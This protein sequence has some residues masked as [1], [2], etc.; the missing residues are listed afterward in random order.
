MAEAIMLRSRRN[1]R[2][3]DYVLFKDRTLNRNE[4]ARICENLA[5]ITALAIK[6]SGLPR[7]GSSYFQHMVSMFGSKLV[8]VIFDPAQGNEIQ[9]PYLGSIAAFDCHVH[10]ALPL[11]D[12][13]VSQQDPSRSYENLEATA[14]DTCEGKPFVFILERG[15]VI[16][17]Y[18]KQEMAK[19]NAEFYDYL[20][21]NGYTILSV[22]REST[23][24]KTY[25]RMEQEG[26]FRFTIDVR[27]PRG[28]L[29]SPEPFHLICG[30]FLS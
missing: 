16:S 23:S 29:G 19:L 10:S 1:V 5:E 21:E 3:N 28:Y 18:A 24:Y 6:D 30:E 15:R 22:C 13:F 9:G 25:K 11:M 12:F 26:R 2:K 4:Q 27:S 8:G 7:L 17:D 14:I 20:C